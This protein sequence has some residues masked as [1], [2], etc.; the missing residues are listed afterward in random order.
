MEAFEANIS[1]AAE[2]EKVL[3]QLPG[4]IN[5]DVQVRSLKKGAQIV[6]K[7]ARQNAPRDRGDLAKSVTVRKTA[8]RLRYKDGLGLVIVTVR[9]PQ[10]AH[11]HLVE[12]G[13]GPRERKDGR[14]TGQMPAQPFFR[15]AIDAKAA[16]ALSVIGLQFGYE[17]ERAAE[18]LAGNFKNSGLASRRRR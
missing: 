9:R 7:Q 4:K 18:R 10:G 2:L 15:P 14:S 8:K 12:F 1:G 13:T 16:E 3:R 6:A 5:E 17:I 11:A